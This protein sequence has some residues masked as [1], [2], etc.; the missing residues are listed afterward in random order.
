MC[1]SCCSRCTQQ[2]RIRLSC[3]R[4]G[5]C[6]SESAYNWARGPETAVGRFES[7]VQTIEGTSTTLVELY[8]GQRTGL[9]DGYILDL[10]TDL[11]NV[12]TDDERT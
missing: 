2:P 9:V 5:C 8:K 7:D 4:E 6:G 3:G 1:S 10:Q 11:V 12:M